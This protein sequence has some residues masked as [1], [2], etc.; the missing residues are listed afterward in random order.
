MELGGSSDGKRVGVARGW[1]CI[2]S[3]EADAVTPS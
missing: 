2:S 3:C 1:L